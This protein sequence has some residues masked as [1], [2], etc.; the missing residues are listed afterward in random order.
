MSAVYKRGLAKVEANLTPMID[1]TFLLIVFFVLV[2]QVVDNE[3][4]DLE[5]PRLTDPASEPASEENRAV[6]NGDGLSI[7]LDVPIDRLIARVP[8]DGRRPLAAD[9]TEF[10]RLF[11]A[12]RAAYA[13]ASYRVDA[14]HTRIPAIV[15]EIVHW[16]E[17]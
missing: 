14:G 12:R 4:A 10:E 9:R 16:L 6:I 13:H 15:E 11:V 5:L 17:A 1:M 2:S 3:S 8:T 7:W